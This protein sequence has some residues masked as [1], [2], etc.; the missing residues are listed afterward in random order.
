MDNLL[1]FQT[2]LLSHSVPLDQTK[3]TLKIPEDAEKLPFG[4]VKALQGLRDA[5]PSLKRKLNH[6][7][8]ADQISDMSLIYWNRI[9]EIVIMKVES[10]SIN[11]DT[12]NLGGLMVR[13]IDCVPFFQCLQEHGISLQTINF[14]GT[15][16]PAKNL[17]RGL[18]HIQSSSQPFQAIYLGGCGIA[19]RKGVQDL[20]HVLQL[21]VCRNISTLDLRY[22]DLDGD[23]MK[24]LEPVLSSGEKLTILHL[25]GNEL[26]CEGAKA[27]SS[28]LVNTKSLKELYL[29]ANGISAKGAKFLAEGL[30]N[31]SSVEKLYVEGNSIGEEGAG[32]FHEALLNQT[33]RKCK[34]LQHLYVEN[35]GIGKETAMKLGRALNPDNIIDGSLFD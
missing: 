34:V 4:V 14:G 5:N 23:D 3:K 35:N 16:I 7:I 9:Q 17:F 22:N 32:A 25:E 1:Q 12:L 29:G 19:S 30:R 26:K 8:I 20:L 13:I 33:E 28:I 2:G 24:I 31:N 27:V 18:Q 11:M 10:E 21:P 6:G 15:D